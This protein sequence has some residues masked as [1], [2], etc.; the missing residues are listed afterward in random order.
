MPRAI[1]ADDHDVIIFGLTELLQ[2][3]GFEVIASFKS[4]GELL[5]EIQA[6][7]ADLLILDF[8]MPGFNVET[9]KD[10]ALNNSHLKII[11]FT[12]CE[13][14]N[15][16]KQLASLPLRGLVLKTVDKDEL[17]FAIQTVVKGKKFIAP[18]LIELVFTGN[19]NLSHANGSF[20]KLSPREIEIL[21]Y[22][23]EGYSNREIAKLLNLSSR[24]V[25]S[26]RTNILKKLRLKNNQELV[27]LAIKHNLISL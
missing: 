10:L 25:D 12:A 15:I 11:V 19:Q 2:S 21:K 24:T 1:I 3:L 20:S 13:D 18:D 7:Q 5:R 26:H 16:L 22:L 6:L 17:K 4:G 27:K 8:Y 14:P 23:A 9:L